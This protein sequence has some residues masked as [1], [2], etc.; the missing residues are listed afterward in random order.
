MKTIKIYISLPIS[1]QEDTVKERCLTAKQQIEMLFSAADTKGYD[2]EVVYPLDIDKIG[3][4]EQD[5]SKPLSYWIG[6]DLKLLMEC[7]A[8]F[9]CKGNCKSRGCQLE[10]KCAILYEKAILSQCL[11]IANNVFELEKLIDE[12]NKKDKKWK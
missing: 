9:F 8:V 11:S 2:L 10:H 6:E 4:P 7:D 5:N 1:G 12:L 3:T